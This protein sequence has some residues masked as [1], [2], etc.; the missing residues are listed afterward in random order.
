MYGC[1]RKADRAAG[2]EEANPSV[3][4]LR[5]LQGLIQAET[6]RDSMGP[7]R[8]DARFYGSFVGIK[9]LS[10]FMHSVF[11]TACNTGLI[12]RAIKLSK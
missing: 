6:Q 9:Q 3:A 5:V 11:G 4:H 10:E 2:G 7:C 8:D 12:L 1:L